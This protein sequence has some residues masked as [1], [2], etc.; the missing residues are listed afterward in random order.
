MAHAMALHHDALLAPAKGVEHHGAELAQPQCCRSSNGSPPRVP[1][2]PIDQESWWQFHWPSGRCNSP[3]RD[4][5]R[6][7]ADPT[8]PAAMVQGC[9]SQTGPALLLIRRLQ[10]RVLP[11]APKPPA[12]SLHR[13]PCLLGGHSL[14]IPSLPERPDRRART[15]P[16]P[17]R[18][19][20]LLRLW[21]A[22]PVAR[23]VLELAPILCAACAQPFGSEDDGAG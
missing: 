4:A 18:P 23:S 2:P 10:V 6:W 3:G 22:H 1:E 9:T 15:G 5:T 16:V 14:I 21:T 8:H 19:G 7:T 20:L 17:Q 11:G 12:Q 13:L